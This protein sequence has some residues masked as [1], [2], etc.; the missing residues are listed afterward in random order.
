LQGA[1]DE[2]VRNTFSDDLLAYYEQRK[3]LSTE[4]DGDKLLFYRISKRLSPMDIR[5]FMEQG[6]A[7]FSL[8]KTES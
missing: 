2:A 1:E 5:S 4:G 3:D 6:F 8:V 7:L